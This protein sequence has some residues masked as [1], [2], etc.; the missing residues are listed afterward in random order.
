LTGMGRSDQRRGAIWAAGWGIN[1]PDLAR[2]A[3]AA[4]CGRRRGRAAAQR[5]RAAAQGPH[6]AGV[7]RWLRVLHQNVEHALANST[8]VSRGGG[9]DAQRRTTD[10]GGGGAPAK[11]SRRRGARTSKPTAPEGSLHRGGSSEQLQATGRRRDGGER[12]ET[13]R[14]RC[15][16]RVVGG[17][18]ARLL[19]FRGA[20]AVQHGGAAHLNRRRCRHWLAGPGRRIERRPDSGS[21][22]SWRRGGGGR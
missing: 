4:G 9:D 21:C 17:I 6:G 12:A 20:G 11:T 16:A 5:R 18:G 13:K 22:P 10:S 3:T 14:R 7:H 2:E 19:G 1:G 15:R 8:G